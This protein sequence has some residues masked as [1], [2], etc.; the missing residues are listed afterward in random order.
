MHRLLD[1]LREHRHFFIVVALLTLATTFP[2]IAY[3][4]RTDVF[5][6]PTEN[7]DIYT[8]IWDTWYSQLVLTGQADRSYTNLMFYPEGIDLGRHSYVLPN[9]LAVMVFKLILPLSNAFSLAWLLIIFSCALAAYVY[10]LWLFED[11]W[12]ALFGA[13]VF[14]LSPH[15]ASEPHHPDVTYIVP[16]PLVLYCFH[17]GVREQRT[18]LII[19][20]GLL[21]GLT[22]MGLRYTYAIILIMLGLYACAFALV[23][24]R[25][26]RYWR[27]FALLI[28]VGAVSSVWGVYPLLRSSEVAASVL[29][30]YGGRQLYSDAISFLVNHRHPLFGPLLEGAFQTPAHAQTSTTSF[31]GYLPLLLICIGLFNR[32]T[33]RLML[34]WA[35]LCGVFLLL[36][37]GPVLKINGVEYPDILLLKHFLDQIPPGLFRGFVATDQFMAGAVLPLAALTCVGLVALRIR[38]P[39]PIGPAVILALVLIVAFEY[40]IPLHERIVPQERFDFID[41]LKSEENLGEIRLIYIP[42]G[43]NSSVVY[44]RYQVLSGYP[45]AEGHIARTPESAYDYIRANYLLQAWR[46]QRPINCEISVRDFYL[47]D[48]A[49]LEADGFSHVVFHR[50]L[51]DVRKIGQSFEYARPSYEDQFVSVYRLEDLRESCP[52]E[53]DARQRFA[54]AYA[55]TLQNSLSQLNRHG[56]AVILA[57]TIEAADLLIRHTR[58]YQPAGRP[59]SLIAS[60]DQAKTIIQ[61]SEPTDPEV[62]K[63][64]WLVNV[65]GEFRAAQTP[66]FQDWFTERFHFCQRFH[67]EAQAHIDLYLSADIPCSAMD[68]SSALEVQYDS[69]ARLHNFS[70]VARDGM[71]HFF[72]AWTNN[73]PNNYSFSLQFIDMTGHKALQYDS[74]INRDLLSTHEIDVSSLP[75]GAYSVKLIVYDFETQISQGG[76]V[77]SSG[78]RFERELE[79]ARIEL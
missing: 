22:S 14:A 71:L 40:Y 56:I 69:G 50:P 31:L 35:F 60:D 54:A 18:V 39:I 27:D 32:S 15:V 25:Q 57:P 75:A 4:F 79:V 11:K 24:W 34:P 70:H 73:A 36:R 9:I 12:I 33:R 51:P 29:G 16:I 5:W 17:R 2:T 65:P 63:A 49:K 62:Q 66:A 19:L 44:K 13:V 42:M 21:T 3:V 46:N 47:S 30:W 37:L 76:L 7:W 72:T 55:K 61:S 20:A 6:L 45:H 74:V 58:D 38:S 8:H 67:E 26:R 52:E 28:L 78:Q 68:E 41:W 53:P 77:A 59:V 23:N 10:L 64:L 48:L 1:L 43:P